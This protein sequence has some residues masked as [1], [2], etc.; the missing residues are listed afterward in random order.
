V[1]E[2]SVRKAGARIRISAQLIETRSAHHI[3][4]DRFEGPLDDI[5]ALQD[6]VTEAVAAVIEPNLRKAEIERSATKPTE[7][8]DAYD[9]YLRALPLNYRLTQASNDAALDLIRRAIALDPEFTLAMAFAS[10]VHVIR[11]AQRWS[12]PGDWAEGASLA[13]QALAAATDDPSTL[14]LAGHAVVYLGGDHEAGL[15]AAEQALALNPYS[16]Q[17]ASAAG[18]IYNYAC[19]P[20][21]AIPLFQRAMRLSPLDPEMAYM[22]SGIGNA[23]LI[24]NDAEAA[25]EWGERSVRKSPAWTTGHRILIAGLVMAGREAEA[26]QA[27]RN[28]NSISPESFKSKL[29]KGVYRDEGL[30]ERYAAAL[31]AAGLPD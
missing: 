29:Y 26:R 24:A 12:G 30:F 31:R 20:E 16:A 25:V 10:F 27:A 28:Y 13:R 15:A 11:K 6:R 5:F 7:S 17:V 14:R 4:A 22:M 21:V 9:L 19:K 23:C 8:L 18:W 1:L 3:W 2:G